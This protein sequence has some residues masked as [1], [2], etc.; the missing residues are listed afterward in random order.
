MQ[1]LLVDSPRSDDVR[2][3]VTDRFHPATILTALCVI[4]GVLYRFFALLWSSPPT[5][6]DEAIMGLA[7]IHISK[8]ENFPAFFYGQDYMGV[9]EAYL[10][11]PIFALF[12]PSVIALR[13]PN[14]LLFGAFIVIMWRLVS[15][16]YDSRWFT[17]LVVGILALGSDRLMQNQMVSNGGYPE[18]NP[19]GAGLMLLAVG[20]GA[21]RYRNRGV[22]FAAWGLI[23]GVMIWVDQLVLPYVLCAGV[24][25]AV[26]TRKELIGRSGAL[27]VGGT[28]VG[29][30]PLIA[31]SIAFRI[32][33]ISVLLNL[34]RGSEAAP[35]TDH[36]YG[37]LIFGVPMGMG[38]C[39]PGDCAP[40]QLWWGFAFP[41]LLLV[42][43]VTALA[44]IRQQEGNWRV[45]SVAHLG[46][47]IGA[48]LTVVAYV[49]SSAAANTPVECSRYLSCLL[50]SLP[51]AL[52]P[53]WQLPQHRAGVWRMTAATVLAATATSAFVATASF[54]AAAPDMR[55]LARQRDNMNAQLDQL[56]V[57]HVYSEY[58][59]CNNITF[60]TNERIKCAVIDE[61]DLRPRVNRYL[62]YLEAVQASSDP[63]YVLPVESAANPLVFE[64]LSTSQ[65]A[66][67]VVSI[68]GYRI[69][70]P[71]S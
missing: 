27:L 23:A 4:L 30:A 26:F 10:A 63:A 35:W 66:P 2:L 41:L 15:E 50:I 19:A 62:P 69:Y 11:A 71:G 37:G 60:A 43:A 33:P 16:L 6:S 25:L 70:L 17:L 18:M 31:H 56:G 65:T 34:S 45:A 47:L 51:A 52:W 36:L 39:A 38:F 57:T 7:A 22:A 49:R 28:L 12:G 68:P 59:T 46:L 42:G 40:W 58:W 54:V 61:G 1:A 14:L 3:Q 8:A 48:A 13:I 53:L 21:N 32:N 55:D 44:S 9:L 64:L 29:A 67:T 20:L 5:N 24:V